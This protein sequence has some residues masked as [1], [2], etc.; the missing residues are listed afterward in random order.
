MATEYIWETIQL[1]NF[2]MKKKTMAEKAENS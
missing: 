1:T 2:R